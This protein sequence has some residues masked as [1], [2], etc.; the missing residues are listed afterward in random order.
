MEGVRTLLE[1]RGHI[2]VPLPGLAAA[3]ADEL[4]AAVPALLGDP[5]HIAAL[6][7]LADGWA[8]DPLQREAITWARRTPADPRGGKCHLQSVSGFD[9]FVVGQPDAPELLRAVLRRLSSFGTAAER[10]LGELATGLR[11]TVRANVYQLGGGVPAH[12]DDSVLTVVFTAAPEA[13]LAA[14]PGRRA[15]LR[16]VAT[17]GWHAVVLAGEQVGAVLPGALPT[18]YAAAPIDARRLSVTVFAHVDDATLRGSTCCGERPT[19]TVAA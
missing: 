15:P 8:S 10:L 7:R 14:P 19:P 17:G 1:R 12:V 2:A 11:C 16:P 5:A 6:A 18:S 9:R 13:L 4:R 3:R